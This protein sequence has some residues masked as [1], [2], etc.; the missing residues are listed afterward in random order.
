L[1]YTTTY[2][3]YALLTA[4]SVYAFLAGG[5][6]E[7]IGAILLILGS[8]S[9]LALVSP[10]AIRFSSVEIRVLIVDLATMAA[11]AIL[12]LRT[13]RFWP[14]WATALI[15][16]GPLTHLARWYA[17]EL[18]RWAYAVGL[19]VWSYVVIALIVLGT[20]CHRQRQIA[21]LIAPTATK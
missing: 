12:A 4:A 10:A 1:D 9:S 19:T 3:Y 20:F 13:D 6:P 14:I 18:S 21:R 7:R 2:I 17:P 8:V 16:L 15:G 5:A 11:F